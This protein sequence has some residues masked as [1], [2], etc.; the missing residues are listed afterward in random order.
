M[1][2]LTYGAKLEG[3]YIK[4]SVD[5]TKFSF[6]IVF[7]ENKIYGIRPNDYTND[8]TEFFSFINDVYL[9]KVIYIKNLGR[10][11]LS[12]AIMP[13]YIKHQKLGRT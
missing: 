9:L 3:C 11:L 10:T 8:S 1:K 7:L 2:S 12:F 6:I 5:E 13:V 4:K